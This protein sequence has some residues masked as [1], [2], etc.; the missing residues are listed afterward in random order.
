MLLWT[1][2]DGI[3]RKELAS[4]A[5]YTLEYQSL[6]Y[7]T[8]LQFGNKHFDKGYNVYKWSPAIGNG[9]CKSRML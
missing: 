4:Q 8:V 9:T 6:V 1:V 2:P 3:A 5:E 7:S